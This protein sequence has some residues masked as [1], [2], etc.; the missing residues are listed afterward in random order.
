[1][2]TASITAHGTTG[3]T[4]HR[5]TE[6]L[7]T[8]QPMVPPAPRRTTSASGTTRTGAASIPGSTAAPALPRTIRPTHTST[9]DAPVL[10][11]LSASQHTSTRY[12]GTLAPMASI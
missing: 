3:P 10:A 8:T 7:S 1:M 9:P 6:P 5:P 12:P 2:T 11:T 4:S